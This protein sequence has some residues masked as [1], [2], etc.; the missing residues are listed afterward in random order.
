[1]TIEAWRVNLAQDDD[2]IPNAT[3]GHSGIDDL[4]QSI[5][6]PKVGLSSQQWLEVFGTP[7]TGKTQL[8]YTF[9]LS[10]KAGSHD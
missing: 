4:L 2:T 6:S 8:A 7:G 10:I 9:F 3:C 1:M 5:S